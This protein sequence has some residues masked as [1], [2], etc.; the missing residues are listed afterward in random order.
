MLWG[1]ITKEA[2]W[3]VGGEGVDGESQE[4]SGCR[5][6]IEAVEE[7]EE[8]AVGEERDGGDIV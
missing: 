3:K 6:I 7:E 1:E 4:R 8:R 5:D 2:E